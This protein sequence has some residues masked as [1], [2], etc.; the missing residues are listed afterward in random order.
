M[1]ALETRD[2]ST[3]VRVDGELKR[4]RFEVKKITPSTQKHI[5][6]GVL[7]MVKEKKEEKSDVKSV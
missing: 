2:G 3:S 4:G 7:I 1:I 5:D 6:K